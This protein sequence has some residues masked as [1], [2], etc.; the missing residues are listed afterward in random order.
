VTTPVVLTL[1]LGTS[2]TKAA[3]WV[4][5]AL[6][7]PCRAGLITRHPA[8][9]YAE[10][11]PESWW[12][13]VVGACG[14]LREHAPDEYAAIG[15]V[16]CSAARETFALFD[17]ALRPIGTGI[18]W[19]DQRAAAEV[20]GLGD[21]ATFRRAT[22]VM[23]SA[24]CAAARAAWVVRRE[25]EL[26][27]A[28]RWLL[29]PR[30]LVVARLTGAVATDPSLASRT[31]WYALDGTLLADEPL[32]SRLPELAPGVHVR[33]V[34]ESEWST[35]LALTAGVLVIP[36]EGDR[37]C[38]A[39]GT[40]AGAGRPMVSWGT[41]ANVSVPHPGPLAALPAVGQVSR[42]GGT[43]LVEAGLAAAGSAIEWLAA[44]TGR[45]ITDLWDGAAGVPPGAHGA[46]AFPWFT[47]ARAPHWRADAAA[48]FT[49]LRSR[50]TAADLAR[51]V[52]EGI[53]YDVARAVELLD[54]GGHELVV[55]GGGAANDTWRGILAAVTNR[56]VIVRRH[57]EAAS[58]GAFL[59]AARALGDV[60]D[61]DVLNPVVA[62]EAP[63]PVVADAYTTLRADADR[64]AARLLAVA[65]IPIEGGTR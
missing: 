50:H 45:A 7:G 44:L 41:T 35:A 62:T 27:D 28:A 29:A 21:A 47:G 56:T 26:V 52:V 30:D 40:G 3:L 59:L 12:D 13:S 57:L 61:V 58:V 20:G 24:G 19:S 1:D 53:A 34:A 22:G 51:A 10:Q 43:F 60:A 9:G 49:G 63:D 37:A 25:P 17:D 65:A 46:G 64:R 14:A 36:G 11:D 55:T 16:A 15:V 2:V 39:L 5:G 33:R 18:L 6:V 38:E 32:R 4:D 42:T 31:G 23:P 54:G 8:P 48:T